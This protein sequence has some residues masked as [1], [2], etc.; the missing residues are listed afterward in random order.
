MYLELRSW[1]QHQ[2]RQ[3]PMIMHIQSFHR[4]F[5]IRQ[6]LK[7]ELWPMRLWE[8]KLLNH[9]P[10]WHHI[11]HH[12]PKSNPQSHI[13]PKIWSTQQEWVSILKTF[14]ILNNII[15]FIISNLSISFSIIDHQHRKLTVTSPLPDTEY[16]KYS[17]KKATTYPTLSTD[18]DSI[19]ADQEWRVEETASG[20]FRLKSMKRP[21]SISSYE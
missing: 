8:S 13:H 18:L 6:H 12:W 5:G 16:T 14:L 15:Y 2:K 17:L 1:Y 11:L 21:S 3:Q 20:K 9:K 19:G 4:Q 7:K 10:F